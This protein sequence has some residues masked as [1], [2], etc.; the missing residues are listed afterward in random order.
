MIFY[1][2]LI[3]LFSHTKTLNKFIIFNVAFTYGNEAEW[4]DLM[5][6]HQNLHCFVQPYK[7]MK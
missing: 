7:G 6:F 3:A 5:I 2:K 1:Q 4:A